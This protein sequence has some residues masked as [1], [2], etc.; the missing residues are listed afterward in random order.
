MSGPGGGRSGA[1]IIAPHFVRPGRDANDYN[2]YALLKS[3]EDIFGL[4][5]YLGYAARPGLRAF[6]EDVYDIT[7]PQ[8]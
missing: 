2:H 4:R 6:G 7:S 5:P 8:S 1:L 3:L